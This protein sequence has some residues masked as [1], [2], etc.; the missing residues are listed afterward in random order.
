MLNGVNAQ[1]VVDAVFVARTNAS[2]ADSTHTTYSSHLRMIGWACDI[3]QEIPMP[4]KLVTI[5]RVSCSINDPSTLR[6]WLAAWKKA[7]DLLGI[8]WQGDMDPRLKMARAGTSRLAPPARQRKRARLKHTVCFVKW[9][10]EQKSRR[11]TL[12]AGL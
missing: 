10:L 5:Q 9:A 6:G 8:Y 4:A 12:W 11:W 2:F 7:H 3:I 1:G